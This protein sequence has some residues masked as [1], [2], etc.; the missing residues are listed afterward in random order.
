M[1]DVREIC[2]LS[3]G[4]LEAR[5]AELAGGLAP[6]ARERRNLSD[7]VALSFDASPEMREELS[8]FVEFERQCCATLELSISEASDSL[9]LEIRGIEPGSSFFAGVGLVAASEGVSSSR[10]WR[11]ILSSAGLG[12]LGALAVCCLLPLA[13]VAM[14]GTAVAAPFTNLDNPW[15]ISAS[16]LVFACGIWLWQRRRDAARAMASSVG[17]CG[18]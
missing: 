2:N 15:L 8:A 17:G 16:A 11:R 10:Y 7:G 13:L 12:T 9:Q 18:C 6:K 3:D 1:T 4:E 14:L 5:R